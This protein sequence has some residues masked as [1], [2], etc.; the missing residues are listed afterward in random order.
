M[1]EDITERK[2]IE[3]MWKRYEF[4]VNTSKEFM[5]LI[6]RNYIYEAVNESYCIAMNLK[7]EEIV[8]SSMASIWGKERF[9]SQIKT[10]I[11]NCFSGNEVNIQTKF[12]FES[13]GERII[14]IHYY[15]F[16]SKEGKVTHAAVIATDVT[17]IKNAETILRESE[18]RYKELVSEL[19]DFV[20][21]HQQGKIVFV[22]HVVSDL[23]GYKPEEVIGK[24]ILEFIVEEYHPK[25]KENISRRLSGD[26]VSN[27]EIELYTKKRYQTIC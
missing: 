6:N 8:G 1:Q 22:N 27:Y 12:Y 20:L 9:N 19:P 15:P 14:D 24:N 11:D 18:E 10:Q 3:E 21:V 25:I 16:F 7:R 5:S 26:T 23:L 2:T 4:I 13:L 17:E